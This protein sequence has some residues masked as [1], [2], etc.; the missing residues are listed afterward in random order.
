MFIRKPLYYNAFYLMAN[1]AAASLLGFVFWKVVTRYYTPPQVGIGTALLAASN[2]V[3]FIGNLGLETSLV[4]FIPEARENTVKFIN[5]SLTTAAAFTVLGSFIYLAGIG[6]WSPALSFITRRLVLAA[7]FVLT[8]VSIGLSGLIDQC[9]VAGRAARLVFYKNLLANLVKIPLPLLMLQWGGMAVFVASSTAVTSGVILAF[10]L[11]LPL[12]YPHYR[13]LPTFKPSLLKPLI[14]YTLGNYVS[15]FFM[16]GVNL[17]FPLIILY[18]LGPEYSAYFYIAWML[19]S[20]AGVVAGGMVNS[21]L[22]EGSNEPA[23]F[24]TNLRRS[25]ISTLVLLVPAALGCYIAGPWL[26][27]LFGGDYAAN[28]KAL[29]RWLAVSNFPAAIGYFFITVNQIQKKI[30]LIILQAVMSFFLVLGLG[31]G[32]MKI[33]GLAGAG[34]GFL[35]AQSI[36][37]LFVTVPLWRHMR[38]G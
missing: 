33:Y 10:M 9:L 11:F 32:F 37:A 26:L 8:S 38:H 16:Y 22:A 3:V 17:L 15:N 4:R 12:I 28:G 31:Y 7:V 23:Q 20:V 6:Y 1:S 34:M 2:L 25:L 13:P 27:G 14:R 29:L 24:K 19:N 30:R 21:L 36:V 18:C 5:T 35:L